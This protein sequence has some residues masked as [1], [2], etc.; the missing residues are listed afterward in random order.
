MSGGTDVI[1][2]YLNAGL[3]DELTLH[4]APILLGKGIHLFEKIEK[5]KFSL[6]IINVVDSPMVTH[7]YYQAINQ[8]KEK[9]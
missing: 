1:Q 3:V 7:L 2:Q 9:R 5:E 6:E 4:I 8:N